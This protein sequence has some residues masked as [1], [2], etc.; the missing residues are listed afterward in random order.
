MSAVNQPVSPD[1]STPVQ[2]VYAPSPLK[3]GQPSGTL[4]YTQNGISY[5]IGG[6]FKYFAVKLVLLA[7]DPTTVPILNSLQIAAYPGG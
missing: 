5:P 2:I 7:A 3:N 1:L 6:T 4:S